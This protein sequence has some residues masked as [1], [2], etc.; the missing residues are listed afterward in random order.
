M[1]VHFANLFAQNTDLAVSFPTWNRRFKSNSF[2]AYSQAGNNIEVRH[3]VDR[4]TKCDVFSVQA[5][6]YEFKGCWVGNQVN[7][8]KFDTFADAV[9][10]AES[11]QLP[12]GSISETEALSL[13]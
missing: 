7:F 2:D 1:T 8:G 10:C 13:R 12:D 3:C 6:V 11:S 5:M 9:A 4:D